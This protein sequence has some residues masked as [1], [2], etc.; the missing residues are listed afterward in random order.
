VERLKLVTLNIW[1]KQGPWPERLALIRAEL[2]QLD[3]DIVGLQE[4]LRSDQDEA[5]QADE[6]ADGL[7]GGAYP[8][9]A[10]ASAWN[11]GGPLHLGNAVISK[12]PIAEQRNWPLPAAEGKEPHGLLYAAVDAP[13]GIVPVFVTHLAWRLHHGS[14]RRRQ[15]RAVADRVKELAP[16]DGFPPVL[17][18][19]LNADP[20]S[21][22]M[23]FLRGLTPLDGDSFYLVDAWEQCGA[24]P[25]HTW[26]NANPY[27]ARVCEPS[28]RI[29]YI[30]V[31]APDRKLRG[32]PLAA[33]LV[34]AQAAG[35]VFPSDHFGLYAEVQAAPRAL[36]S[37]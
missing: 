8:H 12:Y 20:D 5:S 18:G 11:I 9:R 16:V 26:S 17:M 21:D 29:D 32:V 34:F 19:D 7:A 6:I 1:N 33:R 13:C 24:G 10:Y 15:I 30:Y 3:A 23:R 27:A 25:G 28:R 35:G 36:A 22:E 37:V 31:R 4:V 14:V 2:E